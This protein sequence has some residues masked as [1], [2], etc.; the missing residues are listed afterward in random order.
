MGFHEFL[1]SNNKLGEM[2]NEAK[3][4]FRIGQHLDTAG[5]A[6]SLGSA[7]GKAAGLNTASIDAAG[8]KVTDAKERKDNIQR[9]IRDAQG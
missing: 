5:A 3:R 6:L 7:I 8:A 9:A 1:A 2:K 4:T